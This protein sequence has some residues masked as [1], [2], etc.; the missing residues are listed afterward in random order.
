MNSKLLIIAVIIFIVIIFK[1]TLNENIIFDCPD[2]NN[3]E[4]C[5]I[6]TNTCIPISTCGY[7]IVPLNSKCS[8]DE[9][10]C[11]EI[12]DEWECCKCTPN[13]W[14]CYKYSLNEWKCYECGSNGIKQNCN[15]K[16]L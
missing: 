4:Y 12:T 7:P 14:Q 6:N 1:F 8:I 10:K 16:Y 3:Y 11:S 9:L 2:C 5:D 13:E 15:Y